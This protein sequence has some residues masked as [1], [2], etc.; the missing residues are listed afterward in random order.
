MKLNKLKYATTKRK[1]K[2]SL[3]YTT[4]AKNDTEYNEDNTQTKTFT[5]IIC[6]DIARK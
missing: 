5:T 3:Y 6:M 1:K 2:S 4:S